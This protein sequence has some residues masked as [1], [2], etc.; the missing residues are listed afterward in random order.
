MIGQHLPRAAAIALALAALPLAPAQ[1]Q[2]T[3]NPVQAQARV[4]SPE[5]TADGRV[6]FRLMAPAAAKVTLNGDWIGATDLPMT[7][8][9][10]GVWSTT[11]GPLKPELYGYW[12]MVDGVRALDPNNAETERDGNR[13]LSLVMVSGPDS[14][15]WTFKD[16][17][18]GTVQQVWYPSP[19]LKQGQ[20]RMYVYLPPGYEAN[21]GTRY[22]VLYL[23]HGGGGDEDAWTTMG[24]A[25]IIMDNLIAAGKATPMIVVMPNGNATQTVSQGFGFGPTPSL[26]QVNAPA[27]NPAPRPTGAAPAAPAPR[28]PQPYAGS[29]PESLV[30]DVIPFVER[31]YRVQADPAH[32]AVAGLSMGGGH[33]VA[34]TNNNP[35]T[36]DYI[37]VFS[38]GFN[39]NDPAA[40]A[41]LAKLGGGN[42]KLYWT[43]VGDTD[44]AKDGTKGLHQ[45]LEAA[46]VPTAYKE[47]PGNHYWFLW[48][49]FLADF[50]PR[51]FR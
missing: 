4:R 31:T 24:R 25:T 6:T 19:T 10:D 20:R 7:R 34:A 44:F 29:Y 51:I 2:P 45:A 33:T 23:L 38:A 28:P 15:P 12:F 21:P 5:T 35:D 48:R 41:Q 16:V 22:P 18:H 27:P 32:R 26:Q 8:G 50:A 13:F 36:F 39:R 47:I 43:G 1:A 17:P 42:V 46:K 14:D 37:G 49:N 30:K 3:P 11:I 40:L 9:A